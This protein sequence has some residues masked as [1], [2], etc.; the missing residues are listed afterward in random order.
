MKVN[1]SLILQIRRRMLR[2]TDYRKLFCDDKTGNLKPEAMTVM[3]DLMK[4]ARYNES[5][6]VVTNGVTDVPA[7]MACEGMRSIVYRIIQMCRFD[8][9]DLVAAENAMRRNEEAMIGATHG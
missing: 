7:T 6:L 3:A 8:D 1:D 2:R 4:I 9:T 5:A